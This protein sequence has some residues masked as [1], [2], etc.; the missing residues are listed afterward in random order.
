MAGEQEQSL[1]P[2]DAIL[3]NAELPAEHYIYLCWVE[4]RTPEQALGECKRRGDG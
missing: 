3:P 1:N 4:G 2:P